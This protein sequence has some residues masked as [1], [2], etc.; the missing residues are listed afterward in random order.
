M[1][2]RD[3]NDSTREIAPLQQADDAYYLN[4]SR[5]PLGEV[6]E[7]ILEFLDCQL[8]TIRLCKGVLCK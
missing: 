6:E 1:A 8:E 2:A 4:T 7:R 5:M 3:Q